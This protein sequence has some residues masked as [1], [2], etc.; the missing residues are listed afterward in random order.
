MYSQ[1]EQPVEIATPNVVTENP[2][3]E[4]ASEDGRIIAGLPGI[5]DRR[6]VRQFLAHSPTRE[7]TAL[8]DRTS[9]AGDSCLPPDRLREHPAYD[10]IREV[11]GAALDDLGHHRPAHRGCCMDHPKSDQA[12]PMSKSVVEKGPPAD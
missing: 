2:Q 1:A 10:G 12:R 9:P 7:Q 4:T 11:N 8:S 5:P 3:I 6:D